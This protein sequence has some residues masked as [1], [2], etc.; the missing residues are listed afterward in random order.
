MHTLVR[1]SGGRDSGEVDRLAKKN[2]KRQQKAQEARQ[3]R[4][5]ERGKVQT[6]LRCLKTP[7]GILTFVFVLLFL[8]TALLRTREERE[9]IIAE[10]RGF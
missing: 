10:R 1:G 4:M 8:A 3:A 9:R 2:A 5:P 6:F 7:M